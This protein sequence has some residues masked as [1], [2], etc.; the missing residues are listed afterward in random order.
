M[1][2]KLDLSLTWNSFAIQFS[3]NLQLSHL[4]AWNIETQIFPTGKY[5]P[6][7]FKDPLIL[8][9]LWN[10][11]RKPEN[12]VTRVPISLICAVWYIY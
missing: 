4:I 7:G 12:T 5:N 3:I 6:K 9:L 11:K 8:N 10:W 2:K 1:S